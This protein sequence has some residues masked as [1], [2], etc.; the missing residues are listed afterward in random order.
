MSEYD[1]QARAFLDKT[2]ATIEASYKTLGQHFGGDDMKR[3][4]WHV[5]IVRGSRSYVFEF[6][7]SVQ[8]TD[9]RLARIVGPENVRAYLRGQLTLT[10]A[11]SRRR[12]VWQQEADEWKPAGEGSRPGAYDVLAAMTKSDPGTLDEFASEFGYVKPS[13][14]V[15]VH[16]AVRKEWAALQ[17]LFNDAELAE[18]AEIA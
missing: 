7:Q 13:E 15:R 9:D 12:S 18:L 14:A 16:K 10:P 6:G 1:N 3:D 8:S 4:I 5:R 17:A 11:M 2:G